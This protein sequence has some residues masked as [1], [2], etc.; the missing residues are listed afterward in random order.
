MRSEELKSIIDRHLC[1]PKTDTEMLY[2]RIGIN[3]IYGKCNAGLE[4]VFHEAYEQGYNDATEWIAVED[5]LPDKSGNVLVITLK[6]SMTVIH[7]S[8]KFKLFNVHDD[9]P[10]TCNY[11]IPCTHWLPFPQKPK[12]Y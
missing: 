12:G 2:P 10:E 5:R 4:E 3:A 8:N 1:V 6:G 7:Y 9:A 11:T